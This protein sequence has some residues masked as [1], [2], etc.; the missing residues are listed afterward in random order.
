MGAERILLIANPR[1]GGGRSVELL[2]QIET[3]IRELGLDPE[4]RITAGPGEATTMARLAAAAAYRKIVAVGGDGTVNE[5]ASGIIGSDSILGVIPA[6]VGNGFH[7]SLGASENLEEQCRVLAGN[8]VRR[9]DAGALNGKMFFNGLGLG[10]D[11]LIARHNGSL[12]AKKRR[13]SKALLSAMKN[14]RPFQVDI[15]FDNYRQSGSFSSLTVNIGHISGNGMSLAPSAKPDDGKF[16]I[17]AISNA[18]YFH[19]LRLFWHAR[20][21]SNGLFRMIKLFR[22]RKIEITSDQPLPIHIDGEPFE[23]RK[24][25]SITIIPAALPVAVDKDDKH[26][27]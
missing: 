1:S 18:G 4:I 7:R 26:N 5:V 13:S 27:G 21:K 20:R 11:A 17:C 2:P 16:D 14:L 8:R 23:D 19:F 24:N 15:R 9:L 6:G 3:I 10:F 22:C 12:S 25:L